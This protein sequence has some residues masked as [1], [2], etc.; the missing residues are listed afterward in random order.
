MKSMSWSRA[1]RQAVL[2]KKNV[3]IWEKMFKEAG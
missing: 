2:L 3:R 1:H